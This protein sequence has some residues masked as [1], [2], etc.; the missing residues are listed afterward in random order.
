M[1]CKALIGVV[2]FLWCDYSVSGVYHGMV[3]SEPQVQAKHNFT[4][5]TLKFGRWTLL[6]GCAYMHHKCDPTT[7]QCL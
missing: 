1:K 2:S 4:S 3:N 7:A 5:F 6:F